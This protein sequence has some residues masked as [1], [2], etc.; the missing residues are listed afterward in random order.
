MKFKEGDLYM[1]ID[2]E[3]RVFEIRYG[4]YEDFERDHNDPVPIY[5]DFLKEPIYVGGTPLVTAMQDACDRFNG[6]DASLGCISCKYY[7]PFEDLIGKCTN[8]LSAIKSV[9]KNVI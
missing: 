2:I 9:D 1:N 4:Y 3:G 6:K 5:P 8:P 7:E